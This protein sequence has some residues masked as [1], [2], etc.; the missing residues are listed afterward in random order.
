MNTRFVALVAFITLGA[1]ACA[2]P[3][4]STPE[5]SEVAQAAETV[6]G[7]KVKK[8]CFQMG[9][10]TDP[11]GAYHYCLTR[12][13]RTVKT[14]IA[15]GLTSVSADV[16]DQC[17]I[18]VRWSKEPPLMY[19]YTYFPYDC[20]TPPTSLSGGSITTNIETGDGTTLEITDFDKI[21]KVLLDGATNGQA[22]PWDPTGVWSWDIGRWVFDR[23]EGVKIEPVKI[24]AEK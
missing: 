7:L 10:P 17:F 18:T 22:T 4:E 20:F 11:G 2:A 16:L 3:E 21:V 6:G 5:A 19:W 24:E 14:S 23:K 1:A 12:G 13:Y 15:G 8:D 9:K